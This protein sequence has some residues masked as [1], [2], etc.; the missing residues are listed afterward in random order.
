MVQA[1]SGH[2]TCIGDFGSGRILNLRHHAFTPSSLPGAEL[3][4]HGQSPAAVTPAHHQ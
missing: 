1:M 2:P 3:R 4:L